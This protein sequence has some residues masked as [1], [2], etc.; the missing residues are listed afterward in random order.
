MT[1]TS[2]KF[3]TAA[4]VTAL[5]AAPSASASEPQQTSFAVVEQFAA[6]SGA[7]TSDGSVV[8]ASGTTSNDTRFSAAHSPQAL[9]IHVRKTIT[10]DDGSGTFVLQLQVRASYPAGET[11]GRWVVL[12]GSG[13]YADLHGAGKVVGTPVAG[14]ISDVYSGRLSN[15]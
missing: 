14:G 15:G 6:T 4:A 5:A 9:G 13:D 12:S 3:L 10:C 7:F 1:C 8:C 2:L 11:S